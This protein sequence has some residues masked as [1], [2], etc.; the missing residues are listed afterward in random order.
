M[1]QD[2]IISECGCG[3]AMNW[4]NWSALASFLHRH[5][6]ACGKTITLSEGTWEGKEVVYK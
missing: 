6:D 5:F 1:K 3:A 2:L 4:T